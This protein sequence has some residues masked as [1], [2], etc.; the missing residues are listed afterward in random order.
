MIKKK[1]KK[2]PFYSKAAGGAARRRPDR[3]AMGGGVQPRPGDVEPLSPS[4][5]NAP[6]SGG[7]RQKFQAGG[8]VT[9]ASLR[10]QYH[11]GPL[12]ERTTTVTT[13]HRDPIRHP[14]GGTYKR[15]GRAE[16]ESAEHRKSGGVAKRQ[17]GGLLPE[18]FT[19]PPRPGVP[20]EGAGALRGVPQG[21]PSKPRPASRNYDIMEPAE[22]EKKK[23]GGHITTAQRKALPSGEFA[24]PGKGKGAGGKGPGAYPI[25]TP[26]RARNALSRGAQHASPAELATIKRKVHAKYPGIG[27]GTDE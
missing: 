1:K 22:P 5:A 24:L 9:R 20:V 6:A 17:A 10:S 7:V 25:D 26:G 2:F 13:H 16:E 12:R 15:G 19:R 18:W 21:P 4:E 27:Q 8:R 23:S 3:K 14:L 11:G